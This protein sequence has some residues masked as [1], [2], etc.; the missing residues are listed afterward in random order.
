MGKKLNNKI[1]SVEINNN[2]NES[3]KNKKTK[4]RKNKFRLQGKSFFLTYPQ[5][6]LSKERAMAKLEAKLKDTTYVC[7]GHE[8]HQDGSDHLH[9]LLQC[10]EKYETRNANYFDLEDSEDEAGA[11]KYH[12]NYQGAK[13]NNDV[14]DYVKKTGDICETGT[15]VSNKQTDVQL[16]QKQN[17]LILTTPLPQ[18]INSGEMSIYS[19]QQIRTAKNLY[20]L[21]SI[22]VP[23]YMPKTCLW[24]YG[25]TGIGKSRWVRTHH[26]GKYYDK[27]QNKWWDGYNG[28]TTI[29]ID[30]FDLTGQCL[31]HHL[32][33]W[34]DCYSFNAE[35]KGSMIKP[36]YDTFII[37]SQY[38]PEAIF[39]RDTDANSINNDIEIVKAIKRRFQIKTIDT[40]GVT[41][42]D[43]SR[44][45]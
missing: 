28:E 36:V 43:Y 21:D 15:F 35:V 10:E 38:L 18:L 11:V 6:R 4:P 17:Q 19:Y 26:G 30:D 41:L 3:T 37:T 42:I 31:G 13:N 39:C 29:L 1:F 12:G 33:R 25:G 23:D 14:L 7:V 20:T 9:A 34:A 45:I 2:E 40:D 24:I 22:E 5:C 8:L 32:K 44:F 27:P 16:R